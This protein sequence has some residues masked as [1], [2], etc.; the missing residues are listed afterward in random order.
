MQ[1]K[2]SVRQRTAA[3][4]TR[5]VSQ[6][7][8]TESHLPSNVPIAQGAGFSANTMCQLLLRIYDEAGIADATSHSGRRTFITNLAAKGVGVLVLAALAK[9]SSLA[10]SQ[11]YI[12]VNDDQLRAAVE[13]AGGNWL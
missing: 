6:A 11:R 13:L 4:K 2:A 10:T 1:S 12:D 7:S 8:E 5:R 9:H 3:E